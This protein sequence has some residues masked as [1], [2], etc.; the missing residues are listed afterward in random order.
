LWPNWAVQR[1]YTKFELLLDSFT[2]G[3]VA[4]YETDP[5]DPQR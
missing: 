2:N 5:P 1:D 3:K 4:V